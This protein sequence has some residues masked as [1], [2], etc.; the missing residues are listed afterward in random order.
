VYNKN[1]NQLAMKRFL[2]WRLFLIFIA[3]VLFLLNVGFIYLAVSNNNKISSLNQIIAA[4]NGHAAVL[5]Q[6][7][8]NVRKENKALKESAPRVQLKAYNEVVE[9]YETVK[10]KAAIYN[11]KGVSVK[12]VEQGLINVIDLILGRKYSKADKHLTSLDNDL[13]KLFKAWKAAKAAKAAAAAA[14]TKSCGVPTSGYCRLSI[15]TSRGTFIADIVAINLNQTTVITDTANSSDCANNCPVKSLSSYVTSNGASAGITGTYFCPVDYAS[16]AGKVNSYDFPVYN[17]NLN[18]WLNEDNLFWND[19]AMM[20]FTSSGATFYKQANTFS[21]LPGLT[22]ALVNHPGLVYN[23]TNIV[24]N[25]PLTSAQL[26]KGYRN[27]IGVKGDR[28]YLVVAHSSTVK[29]LASVMVA[30]EV[31]HALNLDGGGSAALI[32]KGSYKFGPGRA[33]PNA[34]VFK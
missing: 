11:S 9:K 18:K 17:S 22:A 1:S 26:T 14:K 19:R 15:K 32:Y 20:A 2:N 10:N 29:D 12:T 3:T 6:S 24:N 13:E 7:L 21:S 34:V 30:L 27:A 4:L 28:V 33:L 8:D 16:C 31:K 5:S 23:N 25:Y